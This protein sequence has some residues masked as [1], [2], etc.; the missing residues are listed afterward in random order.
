M[1]PGDLIN[2]Q[3]NQ[4]GTVAMHANSLLHTPLRNFCPEIH[5]ARLRAL[6]AAVDGLLACQSLHLS[7]IGRAIQSEVAAKHCIKRLDRLLGNT[8]LSADRLGIYQ[9]LAHRLIGRNKHPVILVD[10]SGVDAARSKHILRASL[11]AEGRGISLFEDVHEQEGCPLLVAIFLQRLSQILPA[12]CRPIL[13]TDAGFRGPWRRK[14]VELG[15]FYVMRQRNRELLRFSSDGPWRPCKVLY[16]NASATPRCHGEIEIVRNRPDRTIAYTVRTPKQFR[17]CHTVFGTPAHNARVNKIAE[18]A[19]EPWLLL[20]NLPVNHN[21]A[22]KVVAIYKTRMQIE[23]SFRDLKSHRFGYAFRGNLTQSPRRVEI[24]L[25][26]AAMAQFVQ[27]LLGLYAI[28]LHLHRGMQANT[29]RHRAVL[30]VVTIGRF[31]A[32]RYRTPPICEL[33]SL[34]TVLQKRV[35][36][37]A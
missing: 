30:S 8:A 23:E 14:I 27:W 33:W 35:L 32:L 4:N 37:C 6:L 20:S 19:R 5:H 36:L 31:F 15:W 16:Q 17:T 34:L 11:A 3:T 13:V 9:W 22:K 28:S 1:A 21:A 26:I 24:L 29:V 10:Y 12:G 18:Q 2:R 25:L 7:H